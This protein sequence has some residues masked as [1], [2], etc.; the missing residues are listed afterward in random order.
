M[1]SDDNK[2]IADM[3]MKINDSL[4]AIHEDLLNIYFRLNNK[5]EIKHINN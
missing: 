2:L 3:L 1:K 5:L 4:I